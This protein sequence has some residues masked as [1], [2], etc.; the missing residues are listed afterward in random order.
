MNLQMVLIGTLCGAKMPAVLYDLK[1]WQNDTIVLSQLSCI[2]Y[3]EDMLI[4]EAGGW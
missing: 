3:I 1:G 4:I 2:L